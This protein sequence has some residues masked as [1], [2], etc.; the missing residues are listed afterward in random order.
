MQ[1][2]GYD[3]DRTSQGVRAV[4]R[5]LVVLDAFRTGSAALTNADLS[6]RTGLARSTV[7]RLTQTLM[8]SGYLWLDPANGLYRLSGKVLALGLAMRK[9]LDVLEVALP[10]MQELIRYGNL[11]VGL[12][13][14]DRSDM[15]YVESLRNGSSG[16]LRDVSC[17]TRI[18]VEWTSLG[19]AYLASLHA[20]DRARRFQEIALRHPGQ[21]DVLREQL[22]AACEQVQTQGYCQASWQAGL[23]SI[24]A[25]LQL[26]DRGDYVFNLSFA[27]VHVD[28]LRMS[29]DLVPRLLA[30]VQS[31]RAALSEPTENMFHAVE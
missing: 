28:R 2:Q 5:A 29:R 11:N 24:A 12:A 14:A 16:I 13:V 4:T 30:L 1:R 22:V 23:T 20:D 21:W 25:P 3:H 15:I 8:A 17:G 6:E 19:R 27:D 26:R 7:S 9:D 10:R 31:V 18:P